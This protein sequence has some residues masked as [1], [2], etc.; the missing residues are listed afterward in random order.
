MVHNIDT[1]GADARPGAA[2]ACTSSAGA[3]LTFEVIAR[4]IDDRGGGLARVDGRAAPARGAGACRAR[5]TSSSSR[6][7]N[8]LT[9]WVDIDQLLAAF[10]LGRAD[11]GDAGA[12]G[13]GGPRAGGAHADL[14]H[15]QG[16]EEALGPRPGRRLPGR[17]FEKLWGD[18]T[19]L[20]EI[21]CGFLSCRARAGSSSRIR[22]SSTAG[23]AM[24]RRRRSRGCAIGDNAVRDVRRRSCLRALAGMASRSL[25]RTHLMLVASRSVL[26]CFASASGLAPRAP[27]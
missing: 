3:C 23:C 10:A 8:S 7:Y 14:C 19:A 11:L 5:T 1:L 9:T 20:R 21:D 17:Q 13:R 12:R 24:A 22:P 18:M 15:A 26:C 16:R 25:Y 27:R 4:R 2:R 6:Y